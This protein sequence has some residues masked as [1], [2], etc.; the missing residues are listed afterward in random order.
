MAL[1]GRIG[2]AMM[3]RTLNGRWTQLFGLPRMQTWSLSRT[4]SWNPRHIMERTLSIFFWNTTIWRPSF[5]SC[6]R[7]VLWGPG[8]ALSRRSGGTLDGGSGGCPCRPKWQCSEAS[9]QQDRERV[10][11]C[12]LTRSPSS[13]LISIPSTTTTL[14]LLTHL[15]SRPLRRRRRQ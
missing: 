4:I 9:Y 8:N 2:R 10:L 7:A 1:A 13:V 12:K 15:P 6:V 3:M 14:H 5:M 11:E